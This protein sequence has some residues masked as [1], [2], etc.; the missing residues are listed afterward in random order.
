MTDYL[1]YTKDGYEV[2]RLY[3]VK[4][5]VRANPFLIAVIY[6]PKMPDYAWA[7]D[8]DPRTGTWVSGHYRYDSIAEAIDSLKKEYRTAKI[9]S[10]PANLVWLKS[11][12]M[13]RDGFGWYELDLKHLMGVGNWAL[14]KDA[15]RISKSRGDILQFVVP[16]EV[17]TFGNLWWD[18][19]HRMCV[20]FLG[21]SAY[22]VYADGHLRA[23]GD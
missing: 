11:D 22:Q 19:K 8:Y 9:V 4:R 16:S 21:D 15:Y 23:V 10:N 18:T 1:R 6:R 7:Y 17:I 2:K 14:F 3:W 12:Y 5:N 13:Q 20:L